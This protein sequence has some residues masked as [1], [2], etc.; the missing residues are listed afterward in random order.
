M[1]QLARVDVY[2][3]RNADKWNMPENYK[4][5]NKFLQDTL[6][7]WMFTADDEFY[8]TRVLPWQ[9]IDQ[10]TVQWSTFEANAHLMHMTPYQ[11]PS[12]LVTQKRKFRKASLVRRGIA[13]EFEHDFLRTP[14]GRS[15]F[16]AAL[17]QMGRSVQETANAEC[18][19]TLVHSHRYQQ[20]H[21]RELGIAPL[22]ELRMNLKKDK[23]R[24][25]IVQKTK[26]GLEKLDMEISKEMNEYRGVANGW[27]IPEEIS[28]YATIVRP[29]K[30]DYYI[31]GPEGPDRVNGRGGV[32]PASANAPNLDRVEAQHMVRNNPA[33]IV[34]TL[35][36]DGVDREQEELL[37]RVRQIG[38]FFSMMDTTQDYTEY[39]TFHRSI[40]VYSQ[41]VDDMVLITMEDG[42]NGCE[43]WDTNGKVRKISEASTTA[44]AE[45]RQFFLN[46]SGTN[47]T[48][49]YIYQIHPD[50]IPT[51]FLMHAAQTIRQNRTMAE[52]QAVLAKLERNVAL[53]GETA[54]PAHGANVGAPVQQTVPSMST[55]AVDNLFLQTLVHGAP[56]GEHRT[57]LETIAASAGTVYERG[58][59][60]RQAIFNMVES[61]VPGMQ[62]RDTPPVEEWYD[63]RVAQHKF[64]MNNAQK[65]AAP[66]QRLRTVEEG[67][68]LGGI[69]QMVWDQDN[70]DGGRAAQRQAE[71]RARAAK[72]GTFISRHTDKIAKSGYDPELQ[73]LATE[74]LN[75]RVT[76]ANM[77]AMAAN[78][79]LLPMNFLFLRPH[80][81]YATKT[82][83]KCQLDGGSGYTFIGNSNLQISHEAGRKMALMH[84]T[85]HMRSVI[86]N[87]K[88][89]Y[90]QPDVMVI[91][92]EGGAGVRFYN[93]NTYR[94]K[95]LD[96]LV[97][98]IICVAI[99]PAETQI[100]SPMDIS[101]RFHTEYSI[102]LTA[103]QRSEPLHY[104][105][106]GFYNALYHFHRDI[107]GDFQIP[108]VGPGRTHVNRVCYQGHQQNYNP[109]TKKHD[110]VIVNK[111]HWTKNVYAG[112]RHIREGAAE[113]LEVHNY[114][115]SAGITVF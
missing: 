12:S 75:L 83:V 94:Q 3:D 113:V 37:T 108:Y 86:T 61:R 56:A 107:D 36:V 50:F 59:R 84:Y 100:P 35:H 30:T 4:G 95:D 97:N 20:Q 51:N 17:G 52:A 27:L 32:R 28:I 82:I 2:E 18:V 96:D 48:V 15:S 70:N 33:F 22:S 47:E 54:F 58:E 31:S 88:N 13:A 25:A 39:R 114:A 43:L 67:M 53:Q 49:D 26:N 106:A 69:G 46:K 103:A 93:E 77:L 14:L 55:E 76:K 79:I 104:S 65:N 74:Y 115:N 42:I 60:I 5:Q 21:L 90:V 71:E 29:E 24:F 92:A 19:R 34:K 109:G 80:M 78:N 44:Q 40:M 45:L 7:D 9:I 81:Q 99:P 16:L 64:M 91:R 66:A 41:E 68:G 72:E 112:C 111:G 1:P 62:W 73:A 8:T 10:I 89:V 6:E 87:P 23:E 110:Q 102:P 63:A 85:T 105:S 57:K 38:E 11:T 98:S 101:G